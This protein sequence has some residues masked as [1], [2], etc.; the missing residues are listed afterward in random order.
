MAIDFLQHNEGLVI[1]NNGGEL[2]EL[3]YGREIDLFLFTHEGRPL[4]TYM[5]YQDT[6]RQAKW[7]VNLNDEDADYH[8][9][10]G[11]NEQGMKI[12]IGLSGA[13]DVGLLNPVDIRK[14]DYMDYNLY[15]VYDEEVGVQVFP[16]DPEDD[17][18]PQIEEA[19][20]EGEGEE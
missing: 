18:Q 11:H 10:V 9:M 19:A 12:Y 17:E 16:E 15:I 7:T 2:I 6:E 13:C 3:E 20:A 14:R 8:L 4:F 1:V 5:G